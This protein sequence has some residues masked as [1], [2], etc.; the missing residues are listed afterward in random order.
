MNQ[1]GEAWNRLVGVLVIYLCMY[2]S[3]KKINTTVLKPGDFPGK[4]WISAV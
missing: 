2:F 1:L 4:V 3:G